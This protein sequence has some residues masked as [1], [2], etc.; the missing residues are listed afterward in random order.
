MSLLESKNS[1]TI[2]RRWKN[3]INQ[4]IKLLFYSNSRPNL[5]GWELRKGMNDLQGYDNFPE[6]KIVIAAL[7]ACRRVNEP[8][9]ATRYLEA[10]KVL[11]I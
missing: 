10:L 8:S 6:P 11:T 2:E 4:S 5:D 3:D 9:L 7:E 1:L